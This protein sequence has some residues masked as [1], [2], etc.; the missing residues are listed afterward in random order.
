MALEEDAHLV[1]G[2]ELMDGKFPAG[3][4]L[5]E[6]PLP[7]LALAAPFV[8]VGLV[9]APAAGAQHVVRED[10]LMLRLARLERPLEPLVLGVADRD[11]PPIAV[12]LIV[13]LGLL[14]LGAE[15]A[16]DQRRRMPVVVEDHEQRVAPGPGA[17][18]LQ[19]A[20]VL[21]R[22]LAARVETI[23]A[24]GRKQPIAGHLDP[25][26]DVA[27]LVGLL[28]VEEGTLLVVAVHQE[29]AGLLAHEAEERA[30]QQVG[31]R[32]RLAGNRP[33]LIH[34]EVVADADVE[35]RP[36]G[37]RRLERAR[38]ELRVAALGALRMGVAL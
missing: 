20:D 14:G 19:P 4:L 25:H 21:E 23:R 17:V 3:A 35:I 7:L 26:R 8:E 31:R 27:T 28:V 5:L 2:H 1:L 18:A 6:R 15:P 10:E 16:V 13:A 38:V 33:R 30:L 29:H 37:G 34:A 32:E 22:R 24:H 12:L 9:D 11:A 36:V